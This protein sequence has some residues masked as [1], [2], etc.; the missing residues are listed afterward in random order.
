M[1]LRKNVKSVVFQSQSYPKFHFFF[2]KSISR[3]FRE[4]DFTKKGLYYTFSNSISLWQRCN[5]ATSIA[6]MKKNRCLRQCWQAQNLER[7][8]RGIETLRGKRYYYTTRDDHFFH[9][10]ASTS[11]TYT[12]IVIL[13]LVI[14][15]L[16]D[17]APNNLVD[18]KFHDFVQLVLLV[19]KNTILLYMLFFF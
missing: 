4:I 1:N 9:T 17:N 18:E 2:V 5:V 13:V 11:Y 10:D 7:E 19:L 15:S 8:S 14:P 12:C 6:L 3:N 16:L